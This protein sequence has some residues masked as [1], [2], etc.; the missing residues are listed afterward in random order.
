MFLYFFSMRHI[1]KIASFT[2]IFM[3][4]NISL[5]GVYVED[6]LALRLFCGR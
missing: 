1:P 5:A 3:A 4:A 6:V 2:F